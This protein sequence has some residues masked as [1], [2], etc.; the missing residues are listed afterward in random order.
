M[1]H[2]VLF[3]LL[4]LSG[5]TSPP[6]PELAR[7]VTIYRDSYGIPHVFGKTD[8]ATAFGFGYAQAEDNYPRIEDNYLRSLGRHAEVAGESGVEA[9]R[10]NRVLEIPRLAR[11]EYARLPVHLRGV[12]DGYAAGIN[13]WLARHPAG[14]PR[15]LGRVEPWHPLAFIRYNYYQN[16]FFWSSGIE[17][18]DVKLAAR[19]SGMMAN[20]GSNGWVISPSRSATGHALLFI[21]PHLPF[22]GPGQV[23]EG[24]VHSATG[25]NF[26]GYTRLGFPFPYV[27]HNQAVGWVSTDNAADQADL[28]FETFDDSLNPLA[29]RYGAGHRVATQWTDT[30]GVRTDGGLER[31]VL[32]LRKTHHGPIVGARDGRPLAVR[33]A[34]FNA[35]GWLGEWYAMTRARTV[36]ELKTALAPRAMLFGNVMAAD[37][38]GET[39]YVYNG[40]IPKRDSRFDWR[41]PVEGSDTTTEWRGY[42]PLDQLPQLSDPAS[43]WMQNCNTSPFL[44]TD[45]GN[46]DPAKFP[47]Y[48]V[49]E[50]DNPRGK[51]SRL[52]LS[53]TAKFSWEDWVRA[54]F[55]TRV[56]QADSVLPLLL[57]DARAGPTGGG[58]AARAEALQLLSRWNRRSDTASVATSLFDAWLGAAEELEQA[59]PGDPA[60]RLVAL[61]S[62]LAGLT[63]AF[64]TWQVP[65]G[66]V[67]RLQRVNDLGPGRLPFADERPSVAVAG[68]SGRDG[69]VFTFYGVSARGQ[70]RRYGVAGASY[71]SVVEFGPRIRAFAVHVFGAS[72][73]PRSPHYFD[74]APLY[75]RGEFRPAWFTLEEIKA[76]LE[77]AYHPGEEGR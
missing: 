14:T 43:G 11:A 3:A 68:V 75:A 56:I 27:G 62:A 71:V 15:L 18:S 2:S 28:Y 41:N 63:R 26:T 19:S 12:V 20:T 60:N 31:R 36:A 23:Y 24:Q 16:G 74:Q 55:D 77:R 5:P 33:M 46:P 17:D 73:D 52:L 44:L 7:R 30:I 39:Y 8:A 54:G 61:D 67:N 37:T 69:A 59:R 65:W 25:W 57:A 9:D 48:M 58:P 38:A 13:Y 4:F 35:D 51:V 53:Q 22:F 76:N 10:L 47:A 29:Y 21:N 6:E 45:R 72:G 49:T 70:K 32:T 34:R 64:D 40:A 66:E 42:H 1:K 50:G